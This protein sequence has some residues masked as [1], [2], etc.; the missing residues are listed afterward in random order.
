MAPTLSLKGFHW[1]TARSLMAVGAPASVQQSLVSVSMVVLLG[2][3]NGFGKEAAAAFGAGSRIDMLAFM[4]AMAF[5]MSVSAL[6]G[7]N[8]GAGRFDRVR[9]V[10]RWG[11][12]LC[13]GI[14]LAA[15]ILVVTAPRLILRIFT[16]DPALI[17]LGAEYLTVVGSC[18]VLFAVMFVANGVINGSGH[19]LI[20]TI[21]SL[22]SLWG[23][24]LPLAYWLSRRWEDVDGVWWAMAA[25]FAVSMTASL[26]Y[27]KTG[28]WRRPVAR[29]RPLPATPEAVFGDEAGEA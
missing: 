7:Q 21:I 17:D 3:V 24:R 27:Y 22:V 11:C 9:T 6:S 29:P 14:T 8:I 12:L 16:P 10:F 13:G 18:Y 4:P 25:S 1:P 5:S 28:W 26:V 2:I 19:T 20:T 15:S 23:V